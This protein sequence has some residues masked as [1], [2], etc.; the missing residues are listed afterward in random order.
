MTNDVRRVVDAVWRIESTRVIA[1][2][3]RML[4]DLDLAEEF[5]QDALVADLC[6]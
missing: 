1:S 3:A 6:R 5:A 2:L 4:R